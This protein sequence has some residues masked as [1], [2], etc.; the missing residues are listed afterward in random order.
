MALSKLIDGLPSHLLDFV[1]R[2]AE[3]ILL[4]SYA[5]TPLSAPESFLNA[6]LALCLSDFD[7]DVLQLIKLT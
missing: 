3:K 4:L 1:K 6:K 7:V 5:F 2:H